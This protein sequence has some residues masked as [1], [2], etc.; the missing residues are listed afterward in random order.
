ME[1]MKKKIGILAA[2]C[3][4]LA[5][6]AWS[7]ARL[8]E[9][10]VQK[11][12]ELIIPYEKYVLP[13]GLT[14]IIHEDH[15]DPVV[16]VD[17]TYHVGSN[18][19][20][21]GKSGFAHFFEHMLFQG[22]D[23]VADEQHFKI[24]TEA[25]GTLNGSTNRDRTNYYQTVP[26]NQLEKILWLEADRMGFFLDAVTQKKFE[27]QRSTVKNEK[28]QNY[29][30]KPYGLRFETIHKYLYPYGHPYSWPTIGYV[31]DLNRVALQDLK[32]FFLRW[33]GPNNAAITVGGDVKP[34]TV[35]QLVEKYFGSIKAGPKVEPIRLAPFRLDSNR[36]VSYTDNYA[37]AA[38]LNLTY[39][40][41]P[42]VHPDVPALEALSHILGQGKNSIL[43]QQFTKKQLALQAQA[44]NYLS[45]LSGEF[46]IALVPPP[47]KGL[48]EMEK[49][50]YAALDSFEKRGITDEDMAKFKGTVESQVVNSLQSVSGKV[51]QLAE[52]QYLTKNPNRIG[53]ELA[54]YA[55]LTKED[56]MRVYNQY[57]KGKAAV[58]LSIV[59]KGQEALVAK[60]DNFQ[61]DSSG[62]TPPDYGYAGLQYVKGK[63]KFD[64]SRVPASGPAP[65][66]K[67]PQFWRKDLANGARVIGTENTEI[68]MVTLSITLP[69]GH[70]MQANDLGKAGLSSFF[71]QMMNEDTRN[72]TAEQFAVEMQKLG[73][74]ISI[75]ST[76]DGLVFSVQTLK[77]NLDATLSLL[78]ERMFHPVFKPEVFDRLQ[79]QRIQGLKLQKAQPAAVAS[80]VFAKLNYGDNHI[81]G[82]SPNGTEETI[83]QLSLKDIRDYYQNNMTSQEA[84]VVIVG[85]VKEQEILPKLAFL[86]R[87]P[88]KKITLPAVAAAP[89]VDKSKVYIVDVPN[90]AQSEFR[91]GYTTE[92]KYDP[93]GDHYKAQLSNYALGGSFTSRLNLNLREDKGWTYGAGSSFN[94]SDYGGVYQFSSGIR[95]DATDSAL[96]EIMKDIRYYL[97]TGPTQEE[98]QFMKRAITQGDARSYETGYQKAAFI[99]KILDYNLPANYTEQQAKI[100]N[101]LTQEQVKAYANRFIQPS[102]MNILLVGDKNKILEGVKKLGYEIEE[103]DNDGNK[104]GAKKAF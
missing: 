84:K 31:E 29:D 93:L 46:H 45:E 9:K 80:A 101:D 56:I 42:T 86:D 35:V 53:R 22:S 23:H 55:S 81:L 17:V 16:H 94:A 92:M 74:F 88:R 3:L 79:K 69:G 18:R 98:L 78:Q 10:V 48:A 36:Y 67:V 4:W 27:V 34:A 100:L 77:K 99:G 83:S 71:A 65:V 54:A 33:Y 7:Q 30:N 97:E 8:V 70:L 85:D 38:M 58:I 14:L 15:S 60:A 90:A 6:T 13:N 96:Q 104:I 21:L 43:F 68:P 61:V 37:R 2:L 82:I 12:D 24:V 63:D 62:Y 26:A 75:S 66:V 39:P 87:L 95:A 50:Y 5:P 19:E 64:R 91:L 11:G 89:P 40:T 25:G 20:E 59:P 102:K 1:R 28:G 32:N 57:I 76:T 72:Y 44:F 73:S 51:T 103:L 52:Y 47:G 41:V 49:L